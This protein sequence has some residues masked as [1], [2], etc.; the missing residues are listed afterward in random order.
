MTVVAAGGSVGVLGLPIALTVGLLLLMAAALPSA[1]D[2]GTLSGQ[3]PPAYRQPILAAA[4]ACPGLPAA[5]LA[6]QLAAES[7]WN[8]GAV[9]AAGARGLAQF[10]P[11]TW[12]TWGRD[13][14]ADGSADPMHPLDAI[15]SQG[16]LMCDLLDRAQRAG[17]GDPIDVA[18][19]GYNA[20]WGAVSR[21][22]GVPPYPETTT[23]IAR[24]RDTW[25]RYVAAAPAMPDGGGQVV[26]PVANPDPLRNGFGNRPPGIHYELGYHTGIDL[27]ADSRVGGSDYGQPVRSARAGVVHSTARGGPL[28]NQ[29]LVGHRDGHYSSYSHLA[30]ITV[31]PGQAVAAGSQVGTIGCS[32]MRSCG[33]HLHFEVRRSPAW[34]AGNFV[35]PLDWLGLGRP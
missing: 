1:A 30:S 2:P 4:G 27:N 7:G 11:G 12:A 9:S 19:A 5:L 13:G 22:R 33:P 31:Q 15:A 24:I 3:V 10:M 26:W 18:L 14:D 25:P 17:W 28:G 6:A 35:D 8:P 16:A 32:G 29:V 21:Y 20:G 34:L 23:Y